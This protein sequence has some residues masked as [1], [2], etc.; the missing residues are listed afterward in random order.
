[1]SRAFTVAP[2]KFL[3][4]PKDGTCREVVALH[5]SGV[6]YRSVL[7]Q[8]GPELKV[9]VKSFCAWARRHS[10]FNTQGPLKRIQAPGV[11]RGSDGL[12]VRMEF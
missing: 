6:T 3:T 9:T 2:G 8:V 7:P 4:S 12:P 5:F 11:V 1:M 10:A